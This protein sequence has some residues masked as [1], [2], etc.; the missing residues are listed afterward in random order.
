ML[1][2][3]RRSWILGFAGGFDTEREK[4]LR[5]TPRLFSL[6]DHRTELPLTGK[7]KVSFGHVKFE[8]CIRYPNGVVE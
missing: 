2:V 6:S 4:E 1:E 3:V 7:E 5:M 8:M